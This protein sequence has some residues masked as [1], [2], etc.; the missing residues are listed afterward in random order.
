MISRLELTTAAACSIS[1]ASM[2]ESA[3]QDEYGALSRA[4]VAVAAEG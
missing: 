1:P 3:S 2:Y 4:C